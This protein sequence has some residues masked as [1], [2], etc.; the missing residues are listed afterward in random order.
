MLRW[1]PA[2][3]LVLLTVLTT[4]GVAAISTRRQAA[5]GRRL[6]GH[7]GAIPALC[8][9]ADG[10][11]LLSGSWD[12]TVRLW[13]EH[14][15]KMLSTFTGSQ[16]EI[17]DVVLSPDGSQAAAASEDGDVLRWDTRTGRLLDRTPIRDHPAVHVAYS[18]DGKTLAVSGRQDGAVLL[19]DARKDV[20]VGALGGHRGNTIA[21][22]F[23]P[24][25][26]T[27]ATA[28]ETA[29]RLWRIAERN[30]SAEVPL[31][32]GSRLCFSPD[33]HLL[34]ICGAFTGPVLCDTRTGRLIRRYDQ[35]EAHDAVFSPDGTLL[36]SAAGSEI[37][38]WEVRTGRR[39]ATPVSAGVAGRFPDSLLRLAPWLRDWQ[40]KPVGSVAF[41][42]VGRNIAYSTD[43]L[44]HI[45][46]I[47]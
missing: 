19:W 21:V 30:V 6:Q 41:A 15:G 36:L 28:D 26:R 33:G 42:P 34:A 16:R 14:T 2:L 32:F 43:N 4:A 39:R 10:Q 12:H 25:G 44:I 23:S 31:R 38:L 24:D 9:S 35:P 20:P 5:P 47:P 40:R 45:R 22:A 27:L 8:Y 13:D 29:V 1:R 37:T 17:N 18:P 46:P 11:R 3:A 7:G